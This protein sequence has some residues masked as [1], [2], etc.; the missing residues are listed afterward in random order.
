MARINR[1]KFRTY[2]GVFDN[3]TI[4]NL[5]KLSAQGYFDEMKSP[6]KTGKEANVFSAE[7]HNEDIIIKIY[8]LETCDFNKMYE[9]MRADTRYVN[10][11]KN[12]RGIIFAWAQREF[13]NLLKAKSL[14]ARVPKPIAFKYNILLMEM[15]GNVAKQLKDHYPAK[16][17]KFFDDL[18]GQIRILVK[19]GLVHGDLSQF[20]I[21]NHNDKPVIIDMSQTIT[22]ESHNAKEFLRR[23]IKNIVNFFNTKLGLDESEE[24]VYNQIT[25]G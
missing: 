19:G 18:V 6:I 2:E 23:D 12:R 5:F 21:L 20:N 4:K 15:I 24:D 17:K 14:G 16:P 7:S 11:K 10:I 22:T 25:S 3:F 13:R 8:R 9:Y 1:E